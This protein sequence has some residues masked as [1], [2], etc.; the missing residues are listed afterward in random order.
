MGGGQP[1]WVRIWLDSGK[2]D[3]GT[4]LGPGGV[5]IR[6]KV[7]AGVGEAGV[8][9]TVVIL[10]WENARESGEVFCC[11]KKNFFFFFVS[12]LKK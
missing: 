10:P 5:R 6:F 9:E 12:F 8:E 3:L 1:A 4:G 2:K 11:W 7:K